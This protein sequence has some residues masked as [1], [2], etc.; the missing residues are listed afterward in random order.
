MNCSNCESAEAT[1]I[2]NECNTAFCA[3]CNDEIHS[4]PIFR[5]HKR[6]ETNTTSL[7]VC[8]QHH[9]LEVLFCEGCLECCCWECVCTGQ[10]HAG[11]KVVS[12]ETAYSER[13]AALERRLV[14]LRAVTAVARTVEAVL[15][16]EG[17]RWSDQCHSV[18][19]KITGTFEEAVAAVDRRKEE[20]IGEVETKF[21]ENDKMLNDVMNEFKETEAAARKALAEGAELDGNQTE[22]LAKIGRVEHFAQEVSDLN[23]RI[24]HKVIPESSAIK[25]VPEFSAEKKKEVKTDGGDEEKDTDGDSISSD[26]ELANLIGRF[27]IVEARKNG[28]S[29]DSVLAIKKVVSEDGKS[30]LDMSESHVTLTWE[31]AQTCY[32]EHARSKKLT[33]V[34]KMH[35]LQEKKDEKA[36]TEEKTS[37]TETE[38]KETS[39]KANVED[40][41]IV[42]SGSETEYRCEGLEKHKNYIFCL[43]AYSASEDPENAYCFWKSGEVRVVLGSYTGKWKVDCPRVKVDTENPAIVQADSGSRDTVIADTPLV[44]GVVNKWKIRMIKSGDGW[45]EWL[46]VAPEG[47]DLNSRDNETE[48]GWYLNTL[49]TTLYAGPPFKYDSKRYGSHDGREIP[50]GSVVGLT[51]DMAAGT[52]SYTINGKDFG[53]AYTGIPTDK[54]LYPAAVFNSSS[55]KIEIMPWTDEDW[56]T[57]K[58]SDDDDDGERDTDDDDD[59][60]DD[61]TDSDDSG[62]SSSSD[63]DY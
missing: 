59:D 43:Y 12:F 28:N 2:C 13:K 6:I 22:N 32:I 11:H 34:L 48:C 5:G 53:V 46:G 50:M 31:D 40:E 1:F 49:K 26:N 24:L 21:A 18:R 38:T 60:D 42:Y 7:G 25:F 55:Q 45:W 20:I 4:L 23:E 3:R 47:I 17:Q 27:G 19:E 9:H 44:P 35:E 37:E 14:E 63:S 61:D 62:M 36:S 51:M 39:E 33:F 56:G 52:L 54:K 29:F 57:I 15:E 8:S 41:K 30:L 10:K 16:R 58:A